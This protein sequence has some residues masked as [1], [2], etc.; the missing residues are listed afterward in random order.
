MKK[1]VPIALAL[2]LLCGGA[3]HAQRRVRL[4]TTADSMAYYIAFD[5][6]ATLK[7]MY[8]TLP[9]EFNPRVLQAVVEA[10]FDPRRAGELPTPKEA[11]DFLSYYYMVRLPAENLRAAEAW[12]A[13]VERSTPGIRHSGSGLLY[14][15]VKS[16]NSRRA[17]RDS[18]RVT[19]H[20]EGRLR[21]GSVFDSSDK[22]TPNTFALNHVI[23]GFTEGLKL[24]GEGGTIELWIPPALAYG[25][26]GNHSVPPNAALYYKV[27]VI[28]VNPPDPETDN[29]EQ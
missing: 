15:I 26:E 6:A 20:F 29:S 1:I 4:R 11:N 27:E 2:C 16:G 8:E 14:R 21:D 25:A 19:L 17:T 24:V 10:T 28:E 12:L 23:A 9:L 18:D 5:F 3:A 22:Y 7:R 13:E